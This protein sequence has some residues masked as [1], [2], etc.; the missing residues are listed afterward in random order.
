MG[1]LIQIGWHAWR[2]EDYAYGEL[3]K[4]PT[5]RYPL[6]CP[7]KDCSIC[8]KEKKMTKVIP[9]VKG[10]DIFTD[11]PRVEKIQYVKHPEKGASQMMAILDLLEEH[12]EPIAVDTL[13]GELAQYSKLVT[14]QTPKR[15]FDYYQNRM[16]DNGYIKIILEDK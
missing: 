11:K 12:K 8:Y 16:L 10:K 13:L 3:T 2:Y 15:I 6:P 9:M 14:K 4:L 5:D 7:N 1:G